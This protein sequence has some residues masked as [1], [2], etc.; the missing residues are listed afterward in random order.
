[1]G[2]IK[3]HACE[4]GITGMAIWKLGEGNHGRYGAPDHVVN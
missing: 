4:I 2:Q 1:V 3:F